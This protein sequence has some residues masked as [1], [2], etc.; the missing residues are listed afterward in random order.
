MPESPGYMFAFRLLRFLWNFIRKAMLRP[1][2]C[3]VRRTRTRLRIGKVLW[4][5]E[6]IE[7]RQ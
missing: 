7:R 2:R 4:E 5:R 6:T 1:A 3:S